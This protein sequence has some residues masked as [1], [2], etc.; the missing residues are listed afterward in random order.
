MIDA[1]RNTL[2]TPIYDPRW[3]YSRDLTSAQVGGRQR[4]HL[5][6]RR[7]GHPDRRRR[8]RRDR[9]RRGRRPDLRRRRPAPAARREPGRR[10]RHHEPALPDADRHPDL[11][12]RERDARATRM[13]DG[14]PRAYRDGN[15]TYAP[16]WAEY[17]IVNLYQS[18]AIQ[19][20]TATGPDLRQ[21]LHRG[22]PGRRHDLRPARQ[23]RDPGRRLDRSRHDNAAARSAA[24]SGTVGCRRLGL[25]QPR[26]RLPRREATTSSMHHAVGTD[27]YARDDRR[28]RLHRGRRR[29]RHDLRQPGPGRHHRRQ[30]RPVHPDGRLHDGE[31]GRRLRRHL[32][33]ARRAEPDLRRLRRQRHRAAT[34]PARPVRTARL[35]T[36]T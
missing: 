24:C 21:R 34:T 22:R 12:H 3:V 18:Y 29:Q 8:Q 30:L 17:Q 2:G 10:R 11:R 13:N 33:A 23:R 9:R 1:Q 6:Q 5:R 14:I 32:Q 26:R 15:G 27:N 35:T 16:D 4:H 19:A 20:A 25:P 7:R 31:R 36:P 28:Q